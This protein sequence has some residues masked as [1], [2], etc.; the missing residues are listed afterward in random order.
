M[1]MRSLTVRL[2]SAVVLLSILGQAKAQTAEK[3]Q[4]VK[5]VQRVYEVAD[6]VIPLDGIRAAEP[7]ASA[8]PRQATGDRRTPI[9]TIED[10]LMKLIVTEIQPESW[11]GKGGPGTMDYHPLT[12]SL[13]V[14]QTADVHEEIAALLK[15]L[16][17]K[18]DLEVT[19]D[20]RILTVSESFFDK[21]GPDLGLPTE[22][23]K[24]VF[25]NDKQMGQLLETV[26]ADTRTNVL[27]SPKLTMMNGQAA[28]IQVG[29]THRFVTGVEVHWDGK[30]VMEYP[31]TEAF[32]TGCETMLQPVVSADRRFVRMAVKTKLTSLDSDTVPLTPVITMI[33]PRYADGS[34]GKPVPVT[35][36]IQKPTFTTLTA[37]KVLCLPDGGTAVLN[38]GKRERVVRSE[39]GPPVLSDIPYVNR[40]FKNVGYSRE[41]ERVLFMVT[42]RIVVSEEEEIRSEGCELL[43]FPKKDSGE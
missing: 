42:P 36:F 33:A 3:P 4:R 32:T 9:K 18:Q 37:D 29:Q 34:E 6:L 10:Q 13:V 38:L 14:N 22:K 7:K 15:A 5:L 43:P 41:S 23:S 31:K 30:R 1:S 16:R 24:P 21:N 11:S 40:L 2:T 25:L 27:Q 19:A 35:Q 26:Q 12:M 20:L 17:R 8:A 28:T 39:Y